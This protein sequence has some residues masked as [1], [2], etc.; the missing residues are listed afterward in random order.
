MVTIYAVDN[1]AIF[2]RMIA[3]NLNWKLLLNITSNLAKII[4]QTATML[5]IG[6]AYSL[7]ILHHQR[8][9]LFTYMVMTSLWESYIISA[10]AMSSLKIPPSTTLLV[11]Q[12]WM[13]VPYSFLTAIKLLSLTL[14]LWRG[15][16]WSAEFLGRKELQYLRPHPHL[17]EELWKLRV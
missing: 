11:D 16:R 8:G 9:I 6:S 13:I 15:V 3:T 4:F 1:G 14:M 10:K 17:Q 5:E 12:S 7:L 2:R